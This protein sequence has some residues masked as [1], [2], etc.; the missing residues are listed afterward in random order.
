LFT[1]ACGP[2][3]LH[4]G[5]DD[6]SAGDDD[7]SNGSGVDPTCATSTVKADKVPLD[8]M[9]M[10]DQ[11]GSMRFDDAQGN[12]KW[13]SVTTALNSFVGQP[14]LD[15]VSVGL[16]YFG[17][18]G[19]SCDAN[20]YAGADKEI[21]PLPGAAAGITQSMS[22]HGPSTGTPTKPALQGAIMHAE[23]W[24]SA[25]PGDSV[26]VVLATDGLPESCSTNNIPQV[27]ADGLAQHIATYVIGVGEGGNLMNQIAMAGGSTQAFLV[28]T[29]GNTNQQFL[30]AMN[31]IRK[32]ALGCNYTIPPPTDGGI[33]DFNS[34]NVVYTPS[35]GGAPV[36]IP[37][38]DSKAACP[39]TGDAWYYDDPAN[40]MQILLCDAT[41][42]VVEADA[43]GEVDIALGCGTVIE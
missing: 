27:A 36:T 43:T 29:G 26:V 28:D 24:S 30:D 2:S 14:N 23:A 38:V 20:D 32:N 22:N 4:G 7:G 3:R 15:G 33:P 19:D 35:G 18:N 16:N 5:D 34:V 17:L 41:C 13:T 25:H 10:L 42:T 37:R 39:A 8:M 1:V 9:I 6:G 11:S 40:P 21:S 12:E 31:A